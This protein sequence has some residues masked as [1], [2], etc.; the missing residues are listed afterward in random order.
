MTTE[1]NEAQTAEP[2]RS[3]AMR[4]APAKQHVPK[5]TWVVGAVAATL[6]VGAG[7]LSLA[8]GGET[9]LTPVAPTAIAS[10]APSATV[11]AKGEVAEVFGNKFV[12]QDGTERAL[13][14]TGRDGEGGKLVVKGETVTVQGRFEN[15]FLHARLITHVDG[16]KVTLGPAGGLPPGPP[17]LARDL[18]GHGSMN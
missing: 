4:S 1:T 3:A 8:R 5:R 18:S 2:N 9:S 7:G 12:V 14:E 10:I 6:A 17:G 13:V 11:A 15:G 16:N